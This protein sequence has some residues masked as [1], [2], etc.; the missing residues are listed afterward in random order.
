MGF[1]PDGDD[2]FITKATKTALRKGRL[3]TRMAGRWVA[4]NFPNRI[5]EEGVKNIHP[6]AL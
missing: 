5:R 6:L 1:R 4:P 2:R 3:I